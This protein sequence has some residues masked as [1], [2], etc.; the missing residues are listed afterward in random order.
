MD[1]LRDEIINK[2]REQIKSLN[3]PVHYKFDFNP[4][5]KPEIIKSPYDIKFP[6]KHLSNFNTDLLEKR[7]EKGY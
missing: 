4:F 5:A 7:L 1:K 3:V 6:Q 2:V